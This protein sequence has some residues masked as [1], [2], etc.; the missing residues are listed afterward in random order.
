MTPTRQLSFILCVFLFHWAFCDD[1][2]VQLQERSGVSRTGDPVSIGIPFPLNAGYV[3][4]SGFGVFDGSGNPVD[5]QFKVTGRWDGEPDAVAKP[6][7][8]VLVDFQAN[9]AANAEASYTI[10]TTASTQPGSGITVAET[11]SRITIHTG[12]A[13][14]EIDKINFNL[15]D[16][17]T[18]GGVVVVDS[19]ASQGAVLTDS[20][21]VF[22]GN[23]GAL[24]SVEEQGS[25]KVVV[26][27]SGHHGAHSDFTCR[28]YFYKDQSFVK[29]FYRME[30]NR[31]GIARPSDGQPTN[32]YDLGSENSVYFD[33]LSLNVRLNA[34]S[35]L[36]YAVQGQNTPLSGTL[37]SPVSI[38]QES[39]GLDNWNAH[40]GMGLRLDA[41]VTF[42]GYRIQ[43]GGATIESGDSALGWYAVGNGSIGIMTGTRDFWQQ[44][45]KAVRVTPDG[46]V[47]L[48]LFP[49][50]FPASFNFRVGEYKVH[51]SYFY[52][53]TG[54]KNPTEL[55][56]LAKSLNEPLAGLAPAKWYIQS[57]AMDEFHE[58]MRDNSD[59][60]VQDSLYELSVNTVIDANV[61][62]V[63]QSWSSLGSLVASQWNSGMFGYQDFGDIPIDFECSRAQYGFKYDG[64]LGFLIQFLRTRDYR[65]WELADNGERHEG[66]M[67][68]VHTGRTNP[69]RYWDGAYFG[70][71]WHDQCGDNNPH[72]NYGGGGPDLAFAT[73]ALFLYYYLTGYPW[74][75]EY[76]LET[77]GNLERKANARQTS[78]D[79]LRGRGTDNTIK[80]L[81]EAYRATSDTKY[82]E[83]I[84]PLIYNFF[85]LDFS[86]PAHTL[87]NFLKHLGQY[88][89]YK[90]MI[91]EVEETALRESLLVKINICK[92]GTKSDDGIRYAVNPDSTDWCRKT[93]DAFA[94]AYKYSGDTSLLS[95][96]GRCLNAGINYQGFQNGCS[97]VFGNDRIYW[98]D[99]SHCSVIRYFQS[100][101]AVN[102]GLDGLAYMALKH[103]VEP[104]TTSGRE[105]SVAAAGWPLITAWPN[106]FNPSVVI[107]VSGVKTPIR[108]LRVYDLCGRVVADLLKTMKDGCVV[109]HA[110]S[111]AS[112]VYIVKAECGAMMALKRITVIK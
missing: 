69:T 58:S 46:T 52:F 12:V 73:S 24:V 15:F 88:I 90:E 97:P 48:S 28:L 53:Y 36:S 108:T 41:N 65:F 98:S 104:Y 105:K 74:A 14:F 34:S 70:H 60:D 111:N 43:D 68:I 44:F 99:S 33:D 22:R 7:R 40:V 8:W 38:Y 83:H 77:A 93:A 112:G 2:V 63:Y 66:D 13:V 16:K 21:T 106:P 76:A 25:M 86:V 1:I 85:N 47:A 84:R 11:D 91:T 107:A 56:T 54:A 37:S 72:R 18:V 49:D 61:G 82:D 20:G 78:T 109:W 71:S 87:Y 32:I 103:P 64:S 26:L 101:R 31:D 80:A 9:V 102:A 94:Y 67:D 6:I 96:G 79:P 89:D 55:S 59:A 39:S 27:A 75:Y 50:E 3:N 57:K 30:N 95:F 62:K 81:F 5:A 45:P 42:R 17:V 51:E 35:G 92:L 29:V 100:Q 110:S 4:T 23:T 19:G 10:R